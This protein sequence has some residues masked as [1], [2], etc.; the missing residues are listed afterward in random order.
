MPLQ[1]V[2]KGNGLL[3][4]AV[5]AFQGTFGE[6]EI[7]ELIEMFEDSL[8]DVEG[9]CAAGATSEFLEALFDGL[10]KTDGKHRNLVIQV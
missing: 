7:L 2:L 8:A 10:G 4:A 5:Y 1:C 6:I 3:F 9:L